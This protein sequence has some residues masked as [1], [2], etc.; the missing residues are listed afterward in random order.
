[1][2]KEN[3]VKENN[4]YWKPA[5]SYPSHNIFPPMSC[6]LLFYVS[7]PI[8]GIESI[9]F[10]LLLWNFLIQHVKIYEP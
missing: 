7:L 3:N 9:S 1:M 2:R 4:L 5:P 6:F 8:T 10:L